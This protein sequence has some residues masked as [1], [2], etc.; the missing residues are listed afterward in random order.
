MARLFTT[1]ALA[2][3]IGAFLLGSHW[4]LPIESSGVRAAPASPELMQLVRDEHGLVAHMI[5]AQLATENSRQAR[6]GAATATAPLRNE[7]MEKLMP[8]VGNDIIFQPACPSCGRVLRL[9]RITPGSNGFADL[10]TFSCWECG[11]WVT[12]AAED[13]VRPRRQSES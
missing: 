10:Q 3:V 11:V 9:S 2:S 6:L 13:Q 12:Q 7:A 4:A 5:G 1:G 8:A